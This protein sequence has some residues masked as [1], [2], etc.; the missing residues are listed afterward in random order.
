MTPATPTSRLHFEF[1]TCT[2]LGT[3]GSRSALH[4][5]S[6]SRS[7]SKLAQP[8]KVVSS[9]LWQISSVKLGIKLASNCRSVNPQHET[10][11]SCKLG[12]LIDLNPRSERT[13]CKLRIARPVYYPSSLAN[14]SKDRVRPCRLSARRLH[15]LMSRLLVTSCTANFCLKA[16]K[17]NSTESSCNF[18]RQLSLR[19]LTCSGT[20][21]SKNN[22]NSS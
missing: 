7:Y 10:L 6:I 4:S 11:S 13:P 3:K 12:A 18:C 14:L 20:E 17:F 8:F 19:N 9:L 21:P 2:L 5:A 22:R 16:A 15:A 1:R